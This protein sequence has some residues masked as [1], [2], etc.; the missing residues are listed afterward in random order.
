MSK[1]KPPPDDLE[2]DELTL[3]DLTG[4]DDEDDTP[5]PESVGSAVMLADGTLRLSLR[6]VS[7]RGAIGEAL[8]VVPPDD[9]RYAGLVAHLG[10]IQ[11]GES[12]PIPPF[13][14][15]EIDPDSV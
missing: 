9:A 4:D 15:A 13:E 12:K 5:P 14:E 3:D 10:G 6:A 1:P 11:P 8:M 7:P 2:A